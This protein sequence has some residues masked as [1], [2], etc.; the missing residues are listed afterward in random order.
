MLKKLLKLFLVYMKIG[1]FTFGGGYAMIALIEDEI[2][3]KRGWI[4]KE[5]LAD[6]D[7]AARKLNDKHALQLSY[8]AMAVK[9]MFGREPA[10]VSVYS[11]P[12]GRTVAI[13]IKK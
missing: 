3:S 6:P 12:L 9:K 5:E 11:M 8:Y 7:A 2:V 10:T 13:E 1:L 4:T